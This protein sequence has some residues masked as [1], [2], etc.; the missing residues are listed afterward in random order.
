MK[1]SFNFSGCYKVSNDN[2]Q[3]HFV[4]FI[5]A[6]CNNTLKSFVNQFVEGKAI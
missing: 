5:V 3:Q 6:I 4:Y 1:P 2:V